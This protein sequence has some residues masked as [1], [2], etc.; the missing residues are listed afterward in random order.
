MSLS[1]D[2][3]EVPYNDEKAASKDLT[4]MLSS[5]K[6]SSKR[7]KSSKSMSSFES[8]DSSVPPPR[9]GFHAPSE[10]SKSDDSSSDDSV[11]NG[12]QGYFEPAPKEKKEWF[13]KFGKKSRSVNMAGDVEEADDKSEATVYSVKTTAWTKEKGAMVLGTVVLLLFALLIAVVVLAAEDAAETPT[14]VPTGTSSRAPTFLPSQMPTP[15]PTITRRD[16]IPVYASYFSNFR[17][18]VQSGRRQGYLSTLG[19]D[20]P[21][22]QAFLWI[23]KSGSSCCSFPTLDPLFLFERYIVTTI[24]FATQDGY[25]WP[26]N[27]REEWKETSVCDWRSP[28]GIGVFCDAGGRIREMS[29][30]KYHVLVVQQQ[31]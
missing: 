29:L 8:E 30:R 15:A 9:T 19:D 2:E 24:L 17:S 18:S 27:W 22:V 23:T 11:P 5:N 26:D 1:G 14:A 3:K 12:R 13:S 31:N 20:S 6:M 21:Q 28:L 4:G 10:A 7:S 25:P 16:A